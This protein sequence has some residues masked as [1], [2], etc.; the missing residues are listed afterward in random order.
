MRRAHVAVTPGRDFGT[1]RPAALVRFST[2][3]SMAQ[4]QEAVARLQGKLLA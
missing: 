2:A 3:N 4:L 1:A